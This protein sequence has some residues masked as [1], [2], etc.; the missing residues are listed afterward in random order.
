L[1]LKS[2]QVITKA[3]VAVVNKGFV[4]LIAAGINFEKVI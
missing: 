2:N 3:I 4:E 1:Y